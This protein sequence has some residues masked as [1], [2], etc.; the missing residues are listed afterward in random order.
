MGGDGQKC[1]CGRPRDD[2][3]EDKDTDEAADK[4]EDGVEGGCG[5]RDTGARGDG[6]CD[7]TATVSER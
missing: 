5:D 7:E 4:A 6:S 3:D 1:C 2:P